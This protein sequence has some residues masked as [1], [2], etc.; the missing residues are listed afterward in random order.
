VMRAGL[1]AG[2]AILHAVVRSELA[3]NG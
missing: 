2:N 3:T 1:Q